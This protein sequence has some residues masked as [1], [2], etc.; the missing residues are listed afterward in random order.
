MNNHQYKMYHQRSKCHPKY[1]HLYNKLY[2]YLKPEHSQ[3]ATATG[4]KITECIRKRKKAHMHFFRVLKWAQ[5]ID[6][7]ETNPEFE[8]TDIMMPLQQQNPR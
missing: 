5:K 4:E 7:Q 3:Q 2:V 6:G 1:R 8:Q